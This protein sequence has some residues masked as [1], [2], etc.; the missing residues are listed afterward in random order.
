MGKYDYGGTYYE[1]IWYIEKIGMD[2]LGESP[3]GHPED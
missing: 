3:G 2:A 1:R